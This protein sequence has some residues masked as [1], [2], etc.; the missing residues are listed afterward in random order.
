MKLFG[1]F[2][3][4]APLFGPLTS[5]SIQMLPSLSFSIPS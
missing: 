4:P 2:A 5:S 1:T 3:G